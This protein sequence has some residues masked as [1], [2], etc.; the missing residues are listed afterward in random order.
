M[1]LLQLLAVLNPDVNAQVSPPSHRRPRVVV[2][3]YTFAQ[4]IGSVGGFTPLH[5]CVQTAFA[6][7]ASF[8]LA[9]GAR[10]LLLLLLLLPV[11]VSACAFRVDA[12]CS[13]GFTPL[14]IAGA[15]P[16]QNCNTCYLAHP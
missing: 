10:L 14:H 6:A 16:D 8:L 1:P 15:P 2:S 4:E 7:G 12:A 5:L 11:T 3:L 13:G 9:N